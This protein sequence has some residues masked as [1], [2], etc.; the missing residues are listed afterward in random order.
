MLKLAA[1]SYFEAFKI[2]MNFLNPCNATRLS[3]AQNYTVFLVESSNK[4]YSKAIMLSRITMEL[5]QTVIDNCAEGESNHTR[6]E[7]DLLESIQYNIDLWTA[8]E[9]RIAAA[10]L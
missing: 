8:E 2:A 6:E 4:D 7:L 9:E 10:A 1:E 5:A 3:I